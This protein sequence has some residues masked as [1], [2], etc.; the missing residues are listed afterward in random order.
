MKFEQ[1]EKAADPRPRVTLK[2]RR[3]TLEDGRYMIFYTFSHADPNGMAEAG[4]SGASDV[5]E[6]DV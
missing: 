3:I 4:E 2:E 6:E 1:S 5:Q